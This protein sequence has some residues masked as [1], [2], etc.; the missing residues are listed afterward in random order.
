MK[1]RGRTISSLLLCVCLLVAACKADPFVGSWKPVPSG[2]NDVMRIDSFNINKDGTF[3]IKYKDSSRKD[4]T[5]T[6][7]KNNGKL[8][9]SGPDQKRKVEVT[10]QSDGRLAV[11]E[12]GRPPVYFSK[13]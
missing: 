4:I 5:G 7:V 1:N 3:S 12:G 13:A 2:D 6:Y 11:S 9:L 8:E 10:L